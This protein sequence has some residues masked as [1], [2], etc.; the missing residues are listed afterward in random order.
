M[1]LYPIQIRHIFD[2][3][4]KNYDGLID[5]SNLRP[6]DDP[7]NFFLT[8]SLAAFS[9]QSLIGI[10]PEIAAQSVTDSFDD[11]GIDAIYF[12]SDNNDLYFVQSKWNHRG[13]KTPE[14]GEIKKFTDGIRDVIE[15]RFDHFNDKIKEKETELKRIISKPGIKLKIVVTHTGVGISE[16]AK[17]TLNKL[18]ADQNMANEDETAQW[19][20]CDLKKLHRV[21]LGESAIDPINLE[22]VVLN[23]WAI[24]ENPRKSF[25]GRISGDQIAKWWEEYGD[26]LFAKNIR[27]L[28]HEG[29]VHKEITKTIDSESANFWYFNN[30]ITMICDNVEKATAGGDRRAFGI[31]NCKNVYIINGAQTVGTI[32]KYFR[33]QQQ[34]GAEDQE[35]NKVNLEEIEVLIR[36]ISVSKED[37]ETADKFAQQLTKANNRQN[38][39]ENRDFV[40]LDENQKRIAQELAFY[41][42]NY[43]YKRSSE[44]KLDET[45]FGLVESTEALSYSYSDVDAASLIHREP[46]KVWENIEHSRYRRLF[47]NGISSFY[48][49]NIVTV[50]RQI[51]QNIEIVKKRVTNESEAVLTF[52]DHFVSHLV[53]MNIGTENINKDKLGIDDLLKDVKLE[54]LIENYTQL[55]VEEAKEYEHTISGI[56]KTFSIPREIKQKILIKENEGRG[57]DT[58][59]LS[60]DTLIET[61]FKEERPLIR[62]RISNFDE[63]ISG[64]SLAEYAFN[65]WLSNLYDPTI[66]ECGIVSNIQHYLKGSGTRDQRFIL[67]IKYDKKFSIEFTHSS[68]GTNYNSLLHLDDDFKDWLSKNAD[69][70]ERIVV[71]NENDLKTINDLDTFIKKLNI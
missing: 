27:H 50:Y 35:E 25:Y 51:K 48:M 15:F 7:E 13:N 49:W 61:N 10:S 41:G 33:A 52:G 9:L 68:Y 16:H 5:L 26:K 19:I 53:F 29:D 37:A 18:M 55:I 47:N 66:H 31:F 65:E 23:E 44:E 38:R 60:I 39:I 12:D 22:N 54:E 40:T 56:F 58:T 42:I 57:V 67:R 20:N 62:N 71:N 1:Y 43:N 64:D 6:K 45:S 30:G 14:D 34:N 59:S 46:G 28:L 11:G 32:G 36:I 3:L 4:I 63:K 24:K 8:R 69:E 17:R 21:L 70:K 2:H